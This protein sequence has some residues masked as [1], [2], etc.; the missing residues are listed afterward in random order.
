MHLPRGMAE[1]NFRIHTHKRRVFVFGPLFCNVVLGVL[2]RSVN[3]ML[4]K[5]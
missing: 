5:R 2:S 3:I 4:R 1:L